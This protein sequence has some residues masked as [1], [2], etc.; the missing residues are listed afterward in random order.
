MDKVSAWR[1]WGRWLE[2]LIGAVISSVAN[3]IGVIIISPATFNFK[4][5]LPNLLNA[6]M[7]FSVVGAALYLRQRPLPCLTPADEEAIKAAREVAVKAV[8]TAKTD[9]TE[10]KDVLDKK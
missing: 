9:V 1:E 2:G 5:G 4:E 8:A 7:V 10:C 3:S 6:V